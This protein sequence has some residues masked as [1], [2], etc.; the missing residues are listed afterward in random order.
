M[1]NSMKRKMQY[2]PVTYRFALKKIWADILI[3]FQHRTYSWS[4]ILE[5]RLWLDDETDMIKLCNY[6]NFKISKK[7][8]FQSFSQPFFFFLLLAYI[9]I[10]MKLFLCKLLTTILQKI[11]I[12]KNNQQV[13]VEFH[14]GIDQFPSE[15]SSM[16][17]CL[18]KLSIFQRQA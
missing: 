2:D 10:K 11:C 16:H 14:D 8:N 12:Y 4:L 9:C 3:L 17:S 6:K 13:R 7:K 15:N 18:D 5:C 1:K